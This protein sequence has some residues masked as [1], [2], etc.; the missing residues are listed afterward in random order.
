MRW[1]DIQLLRSI[2]ELEE[3]NQSFGNGLNLLQQLNQR[4]NVPQQDGIDSFAVELALA[5]QTG[6]LT[7]TDRS[8]NWVGNFGPTNNPH[9]WLQ[10]FDNVRMTLAGR[11]RARGRLIQIGF[12]DPGEDDGRII[13]GLT[14]EEIAR[15]IGDTYTPTQLPGYLRDSGLPPEVVPPAVEGDKWEFVLNILSLLHD[16]GAAARRFLRDFIGSWLDGRHHAPPP[17]DVRRRIVVLLAQ[18]GWHVVDGHLVVGERV[19]AEPGSVTPLGRDARFAAL[20]PAIR[21]VTARF[22]EEHLDV[23]IFEA[24]KAVNNRVKEISGLDLDGSALMDETMGSART[25][26]WFSDPATKTGKDVQQGYYFTFKGATL[27][28]RNP[29]AHE[30]FRPLDEEEGFEKLAFASMLMRRLDEA[31]IGPRPSVAT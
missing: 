31:K 11:D 14:L 20:H 23:A 6:Y 2:D 4:R 25:H 8:Q 21:E 30:Q 27:G 28:I 24:F 9:Q 17:V 5:F 3:E 19:T 7:A 13:T 29:D 1:D 10:T 22:I 26:I 15:C 16:G 18:Q 12:P